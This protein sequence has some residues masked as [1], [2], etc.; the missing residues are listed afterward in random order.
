MGMKVI[1]ILV[2]LSALA[3]LLGFAVNFSIYNFAGED[4]ER[5]EAIEKI[6]W[7]MNDAGPGFAILLLGIG[8]SMQSFKKE[9]IP[10]LS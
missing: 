1:S 8:I 10:S 5:W 9:K 6:S 3:S 7:F 4:W 2:V